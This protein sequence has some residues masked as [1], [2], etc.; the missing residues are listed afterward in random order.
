METYVEYNFEPII[1][2]H[3][4]E[5]ATISLTKNGIDYVSWLTN[6]K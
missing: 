4:H 1:H 5:G 2:G 6:T 3:T